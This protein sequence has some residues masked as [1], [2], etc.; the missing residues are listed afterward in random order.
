M[1]SNGNG[2]Y[3]FFETDVGTFETTGPLSPGA[4]ETTLPHGNVVAAEIKGVMAGFLTGTVS[5]TGPCVYN[6]A[7]VAAC[8]SAGCFR[9]VFVAAAFGPTATLATTSF[10]FDYF[11]ASPLL[12]Y[13]HWVDQ[14]T[15]TTE[16]FFGDIATA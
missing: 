6:A 4:C 2:T 5:C 16:Q 12:T 8:P 11:S 7:G 1:R 15:A 10:R 14:G 13:R 3:A 9:T